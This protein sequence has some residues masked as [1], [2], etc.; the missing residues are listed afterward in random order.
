MTDAADKPTGAPQC[1]VTVLVDRH[2]VEVPRDTTAGG[3]LAAAGLDPARRRLVLVQGK[4]QTQ[5]PD[6]STP[7]KVHEGE[8]FVTISTGPTPVS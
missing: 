3:V 6:P 1:E 7:L 8:V 2:P 5:Y 4:H